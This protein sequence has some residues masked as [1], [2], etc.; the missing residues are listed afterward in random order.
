ML[1]SI[2]ATFFKF[3][4]FGKSFTLSGL[5]A[6]SIGVREP[7]QRMAVLVGHLVTVGVSLTVGAGY[8][9]LVV[10]LEKLPR[11]VAAAHPGCGN[12]NIWLIWLAQQLFLGLALRMSQKVLMTDDDHII[13]LSLL[14]S[15]FCTV[16][17]IIS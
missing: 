8:P 10:M 9:A 13:S 17:D 4:F 14:G 6:P 12:F 2:F 7:R 3:S 1:T 11:S 15:F 5:T 16:K